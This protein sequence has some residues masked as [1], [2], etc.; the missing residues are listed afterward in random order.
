[1]RKFSAHRIYPV[2]RPSIPYG[3]IET[4]DDGTI[5]NIRETG[6][7]PVEEPGLVFYSGIIIPGMVNA[8]C[9]L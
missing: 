3:I 9:H 1:M 6:G 4:D 8:H 2:N 7:H 5:V